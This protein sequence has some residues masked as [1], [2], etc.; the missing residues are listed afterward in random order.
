MLRSPQ[1]QGSKVLLQSAGLLG[2]L[3]VVVGATGMLGVWPVL[4]ARSNPHQQAAVAEREEVLGEISAD[5]NVKYYS[6]VVQSNW[7]NQ[8]EN[9]PRMSYYTPDRRAVVW[10][11][12]LGDRKIARL[13]GRQVGGD[14][15]KGFPIIVRVTRPLAP[16]AN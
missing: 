7:L 4:N 15:D 8:L 13:N 12:R 3:A 9:G 14:F 6:W 2:A 5:A 16:L 1:S 11:E 10:F